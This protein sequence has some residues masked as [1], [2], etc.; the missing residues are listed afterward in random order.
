MPTVDRLT[1]EQ[2]VEICEK[3]TGHKP[4]PKT[5][6]AIIIAGLQRKELFGWRFNFEVGRLQ[7][8]HRFIELDS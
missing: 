4:P 7:H 1:R 6:D 2:I 8:P 3:M 5:P